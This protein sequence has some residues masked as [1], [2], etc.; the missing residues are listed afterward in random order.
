MI[1]L[2]GMAVC[3]DI[4]HFCIFQIALCMACMPPLSDETGIRRNDNLL[5]ILPCLEYAS[6]IFFSSCRSSQYIQ[7]VIGMSGRQLQGI[8]AT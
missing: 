1:S 4:G 3:T 7:T 2:S 6:N 5:Q 8:S